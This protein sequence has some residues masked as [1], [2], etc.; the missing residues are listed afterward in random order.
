[1]NKPFL[2]TTK[3]KSKFTVS[4]GIRYQKFYVI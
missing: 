3:K 2:F 1:M 4:D